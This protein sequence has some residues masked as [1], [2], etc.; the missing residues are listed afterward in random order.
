MKDLEALL[1]T[2]YPVLQVTTPEEERFVEEISRI[3]HTSHRN[4][5][6]WDIMNS[7]RKLLPEDERGDTGVLYG[8]AVSE[9]PFPP[10][11]LEWFSKLD[12]DAVLVF[13]DLHAHMEDPLIVRAVRNALDLRNEALEKCVIL[14]SPTPDIPIE[15]RRQVVQI[16]FPFPTR[17]GISKHLGRLRKKLKDERFENVVDACRGLTFLEIEN[18]LAYSLY[19]DKTIK[20]ESIIKEKQEIIKSSRSLEYFQ[21]KEGMDTVGG[22]EILKS[23]LVS[24]RQAF[25]KKARDYGLPYPKGLLIVGLPGAGKSL[26]SKAVANSWGYPL[27]RF[28]IGSAFQK[29][30]GESEA[31]VRNARQTA[32]AVAPCVFWID[33]QFV[34]VKPCELLE[35]PKTLGTTTWTE[36]SSVKVKNFRDVQW[37]IS[38][39]APVNIPAEYFG[40]GSETIPKGSRAQGGPEV[41][42][43]SNLDTV[44]LLR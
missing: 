34:D 9:D 29:Y 12:E 39:Q 38:S 41:H 3:A 26:I 18:A 11:I 22:L 35:H 8:A 13:C 42:G 17:E 16:E 21:P 37:A 2:K 40:E 30:L 23:W 14:V 7:A 27:I 36:T 19:M 4:V 6:V 33:E 1:A 5:Y 15:L 44:C 25:S 32:E 43:T 24:R 31:E 28:D 20:P 10:G